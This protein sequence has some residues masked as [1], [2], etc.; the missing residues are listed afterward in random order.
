MSSYV[1]LVTRTFAFALDAAMLT[2]VAV[3]AGVGAALV[4]A[5]VHVAGDLRAVVAAIGCV[6]YALWTA[7]WFVVFWSTTGQT[8]GNRAMHIRVCDPSGST[9]SPARALLRFGGVLLAAFPLFLGFLPI[10]FDDRRRGLQ[11]FIAHTV[12]VD[13]P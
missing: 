1:G 7:T 3:V 13:H 5:V 12:V 9:L 2:L 4:L 10:L 11:D 6:V 8:P